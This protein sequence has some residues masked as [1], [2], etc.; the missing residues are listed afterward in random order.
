[1]RGL[2]RKRHG[3]KHGALSHLNLIYRSAVVRPAA[4]C[5]ELTSPFKMLVRSL[6]TAPAAVE[7]HNQ[8]TRGL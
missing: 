4:V 2:A 7:G 3:N 1:M 5:R 6:H 8:K